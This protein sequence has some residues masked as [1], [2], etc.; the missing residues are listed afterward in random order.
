MKDEL[1]VVVRRVWNLGAANFFLFK[2][3][4]QDICYSVFYS[5]GSE[6]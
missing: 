5:I 2:V 4:E 3:V 1:L 6:Y